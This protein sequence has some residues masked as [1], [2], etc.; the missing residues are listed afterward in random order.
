MKKSS[1]SLWIF[2]FILFLP[3]SH[4]Y[5]NESGLKFERISPRQG[6]SHDIVHS[7]IQDHLGFMWIG[8]QDGLNRYDGYEFKVFQHDP[9]DLTSIPVSDIRAISEDKDGSLWM[10]TWGGGLVKY[11][12]KTNEFLQFIHT[13]GNQ[14]KINDNWVQALHI[15]KNGMVWIG[16]R[17]GGLDRFD[18]VTG[19]FTH[20]QHDSNNQKNS[21]SL[22]DNCVFFVCED[23]TGAIWA[24]TRNGLNRFDPQTDEFTRYQSESGNRTSLSHNEVRA[25]FCDSDSVIWVG[26]A[27]G[28]NRMDRETGQF[29]HYLTE[30][31]GSGR[32]HIIN[33]I[34]QDHNGQIWIGSYGGLTRYDPKKNKFYDYPHDPSNY[35]S[36]SHNDTRMVFCDR[37][38]V[39]WIGTNGGGLNKCD[40]KPRKFLHSKSDP[41]ETR[42]M[43]DNQ[44]YALYEDTKGAVWVGTDQALNKMTQGFASILISQDKGSSGIRFDHYYFNSDRSERVQ[45]ICEDHKGKIWVG[46]ENGLYKLQNRLWMKFDRYDEKSHG[47]KGSQVTKILEDR[48]HRLWVGTYDHGLNLFDPEKGQFVNFSHDPNRENCLSNNRIQAIFED[49]AGDLWIGTDG[50]GLNRLKLSEGKIP[51]PKIAEFV[52]YQHNDKKSSLSH[53]SILSILQD[54]TGVLWVAT[55]GGLNKLVLEEW[56]K[57]DLQAAI[58]QSYTAKSGLPNNT[59]FG[60]LEDEEGTIWLSTNKGLSNFQPQTECFRNYSINDGLQSNTFHVGAYHKGPSGKMYFGGASGFNAFWPKQVEDNPFPP[61]VCLISFKVLGKER[62]LDTS[63]PGLPRIELSYDEN[64]F[65]FEFAGLDYTQPSNNRYAYKLEGLDSDWVEESSQRRYAKYTD[66]SGGSYRF[67][68]K[69]SNNDGVWN[70]AG[71][72]IDIIIIPPFWETRW[73]HSLIA[74]FGIGLII[75]GFILQNKRAEYK[76]NQELSE[77]EQKSQ[78]QELEAARNIQLSMIPEKLPEIENLEIAARMQTAKLVGGD[79]YDFILSPNGKNLTIVIADVSGKGAPASLLM[80]STR[81]VLQTLTSHL[82]SL[83]E[84]NLSTKEIVAIA[85]SHIFADTYEMETPMMAT[86]LMM[87]WDIKKGELRYTGAG[88]EYIM[89]YRAKTKQIEM[90][91][92]GGLWLGVFDDVQE[93]LQEKKLTFETG[94][95]ILLYTDGVTEFHD[96]NGEM[97]GLENLKKF[98]QANVHRSPQEIIDRLFETLVGYGQGSAQY[99]DTT[100][101]VFKRK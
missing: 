95:A 92:S 74:F 84:Q 3:L 97:F 77:L 7:V 55:F 73:F 58:F 45:T 35:E 1:W 43:S 27:N 63:L 19:K 36:L 2:L 62:S 101:V 50:G 76:K 26:T 67:L 94:D 69:A 52:C 88:H 41:A 53:N 34:T 91:R 68:V 64:F 37:S 48:S 20:F 38:R 11:D 51:D 59:I 90:I 49:R 60:M 21:A 71:I 33:T 28:L 78:K 82:P 72:A 29:Q 61:P 83:A 25:V 54:K 44:V 5:G 47:L 10:G 65:S 75:V 93:Y 14:N 79:Y 57:A 99:D 22:S 86:M 81:S 9:L 24:G 17:E 46:T 66:L 6:L 56:K 98:F 16:T 18:P 32:R 12:L 13:Q 42:A 96:P 89:F 23:L 30:S 85:N 87:N 31:G 4:G 40:L 100:S 8:T 39:L 80:V 70:H 15:D